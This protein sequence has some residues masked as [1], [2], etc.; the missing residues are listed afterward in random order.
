MSFPLPLAAIYLGPVDF[1]FTHLA[2]GLN[3][4]CIFNNLF[5]FITYTGSATFMILTIA[6]LYLSGARKEALVFAVVFCIGSIITLGLKD[7]FARPRPDDLGIAPID[8]GAFPSGHTMFAFSLAT[9]VSIYHQKFRYVMFAWALLIGFSRMYLGF[10]YLT[11]V[12]A[13]ALI[14]SAVSYVVTRAALHNDKEVSCISR[15]EKPSLNSWMSVARLPYVFLV[16]LI[17]VAR[18]ISIKSKRN[19]NSEDCT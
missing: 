17:T 3:D 18:T 12:I 5:W 19:L 13:G 10:H 2:R 6:A 8:Q 9:T 4:G 15:R 14:G 11:D 7:F 1:Y 16:Q